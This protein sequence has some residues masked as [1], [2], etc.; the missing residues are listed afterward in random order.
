MY[1]DII[2]SL[3]YLKLDC[4]A[5][6]Q[7]IKNEIK[8]FD[9]RL[10]NQNDTGWQNLA[11]RGIDIYKGRPYQEYGYACENEV[12]YVWTELA[13]ACPKTTDFIKRSFFCKKFYRVKL[14]VIKPFGIIPSHADSRE[15]ILGLTEHPP[16]SNFDSKEIK[17]ITIVVDWPKRNP[18]FLGKKKVPI[19]NGDVFLINFSKTHSL[20][21]LSTRNCYSLVVTGDFED[22]DKWKSLVES[23]YE[24]NSKIKL[25]K[26]N[27][28]DILMKLILL[29]S[30][31]FFKIKNLSFLNFLNK[32]KILLENIFNQ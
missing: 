24:K 9:S 27:F 18:F 7:E 12:P 14:N 29:I 6:F 13:R 31:Y 20:I 8:N 4:F 3:D 23:S 11:L 1:K 10:K 19:K 22:N 15:S 25:M 16:Y 28:F 2:L 26:L 17:Y 5:P 30:F 32:L 21:N